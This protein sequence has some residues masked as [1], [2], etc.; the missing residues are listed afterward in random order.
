MLEPKDRVLLLEALRPPVGFRFDEGIGTTYT[1]DLVALLTAPL[2]FTW[3]EQKDDVDAGGTI[4]SLEVIESLRR[5]ADRLTLFCHAGRIAVPQAHYPQLA[6]L[7]ESIVGCL[8]SSGGAFHPKVWVL[9]FPAEEGDEIRYRMLC[10]SRNLSFS[11]AWDTMLV[12]DGTLEKGAVRQSRPLAEFLR[13]LP[14]QAAVKP[15]S[16]QVDQRIERLAGEVERVR[17]EAPQNV[18]DFTFHPIGIDAE[19]KRSAESVA[20]DEASCCGVT[21]SDRDQAERVGA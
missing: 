13:A 6:F 16:E 9:R 19:A 4:D 18:E 5:H 10:L 1:L 21:I 7:E 15:L 3:F 2:A 8:P 14:R 17:F 12:M 11:R 20:R